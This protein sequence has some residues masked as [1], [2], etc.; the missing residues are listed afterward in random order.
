[1]S[2]IQNYQ[3]LSIRHEGAVDWLTLNR[4]ERLN[5]LNAAMVDELNDYFGR[6][7][8][9][10]AV[11]IV[12]MRGAGRGFC[13]GI[14]IKEIEGVVANGIVPDVRGQRR[15]SDIIMRMRRCP[16]PILALVHGPATGGG[17]GL[18]LAADIRIAGQSAR[19]NCAFLRIGLTSCDVGVS[20]H[21]P[22]LVGVSVASE[23]MLTGRF[24]DAE[25][26]AGDGA[27]LRRRAG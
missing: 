2:Q 25:L 10:E 18:M 16:Q 20:Y 26:G 23:L 6:L 21:L 11:R 4:P 22:R 9:N 8:A 27:G 3:T 5:A 1:M 12:V 24:M 13:A 7:L 14:D 15:V 17:F 19:M